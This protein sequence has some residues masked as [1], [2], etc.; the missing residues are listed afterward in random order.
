ML[1][2]ATAKLKLSEETLQAESKISLKRLVAKNDVRVI[3]WS[4]YS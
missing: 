4:D 3:K 2:K 1:P